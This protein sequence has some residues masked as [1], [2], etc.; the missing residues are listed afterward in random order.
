MYPCG[1]VVGSLF[2][3]IIISYA[4]QASSRLARSS[5]DIVFKPWDWVV[6]LAF[7]SSSSNACVR[8]RFFRAISFKVSVCWRSLCSS[9]MFAVLI[10]FD[11]GGGG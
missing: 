5:S 11:V 9:V 2:N 6:K 1:S 7:C 3:A 10:C 4:K 8:S